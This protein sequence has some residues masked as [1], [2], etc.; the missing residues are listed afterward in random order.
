MGVC[1]CERECKY[2]GW[3]DKRTARVMSKLFKFSI[4][5]LH[6]INL[7]HFVSLFLSFCFSVCTA[8]NAQG[9]NGMVMVVRM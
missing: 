5:N 7:V 4:I 2:L 9:W 1:V 8:M 6:V 3:S